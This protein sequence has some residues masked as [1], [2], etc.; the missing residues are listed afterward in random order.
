MDSMVVSNCKFDT[1]VPLDVQGIDGYDRG[2]CR[3]GE[4]I[5]RYN[6]SGLSDPLVEVDR[7]YSFTICISCQN[8]KVLPGELMTNFRV[9]SGPP[10]GW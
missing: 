9:G 3:N 5:A 10:D 4:G 7:I 2:V 1:Q 8:L 6:G